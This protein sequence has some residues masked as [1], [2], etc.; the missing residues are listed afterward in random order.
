MAT[1]KEVLDAKLLP[2]YLNVQD[3]EAFKAQILEEL[4]K[5]SDAPKPAGK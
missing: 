4:K 3:A 2:E 5:A 1:M